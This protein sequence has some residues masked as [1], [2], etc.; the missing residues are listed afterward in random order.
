MA[1]ANRT[2]QTLKDLVQ[3]ALC[4]I[5]EGVNM[6][7]ANGVNASYPETVEFTAHIVGNEV[8]FTVPLAGHIEK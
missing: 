1:T 2:P 7:R 6:A 8:V 5:I 4:E 3:I